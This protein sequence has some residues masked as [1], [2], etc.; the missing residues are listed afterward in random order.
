VLSIQILLK[1]THLYENKHDERHKHVEMLN[2]DSDNQNN[3]N[4]NLKKRMEIN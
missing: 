2:Q 1:E 4:N 3:R